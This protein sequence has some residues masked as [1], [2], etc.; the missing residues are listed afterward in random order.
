M[1]KSGWQMC[2]YKC[3]HNDGQNKPHALAQASMSG[4][5]LTLEPHLSLLDPHY[6]PATQRLFPFLT[7]TVFWRAFAR[8]LLAVWD[9]LFLSSLARS[10]L[11]TQ[12]M[13]QHHHLVGLSLSTWSKED[14]S[15]VLITCS[16]FSLVPM[17]GW[18]YP[19]FTYSFIVFLVYLMVSRALLITYYWNPRFQ[20]RH[21]SG[22]ICSM[23]ARKHA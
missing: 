19:Y 23:N 7:Q 16:V 17:M 3:I 2:S 4:P 15:C 8:A 13:A 14:T 1:E 18:G 6:A 5:C 12:V 10:F 11:T 9:A 22:N 21:W 20:N